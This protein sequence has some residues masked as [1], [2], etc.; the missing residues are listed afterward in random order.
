M[1]LYNAINDLTFQ[2]SQLKDVV[3]QMSAVT[4]PSSS[5]KSKAKSFEESY[6]DLNARFTATQKGM[7][8]GESKL[9]E[10]LGTLFGNVVAYNGKPS[11]TQDRQA[12]DLIQEVKVALNA[13]QEVLKKQLPGINKAMGSEQGIK[14]LDRVTWD[15]KNG[16][17]LASPKVNKAW[18]VNG[19][20]VYH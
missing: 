12:V 3:T 14:L 5:L 20:R 2:L 17:G 10:Q 9:R 13:S 4:E 7:I 18:I 19:A 6:K 1:K 15:E 11:Q 16:M 8:T